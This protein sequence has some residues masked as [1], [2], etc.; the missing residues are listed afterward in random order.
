VERVDVSTL[1][2]HRWSLRARHFV[3]ATGAI[4]NARLLLASNDV[5]TVGL[6]NE[7]DNVG[8]YFMDHLIAPGG[9]TLVARSG[10]VTGL[11]L[12]QFD[13]LQHRPKALLVLSEK[14]RARHRL[15]G[16]TA[17]LF[18]KGAGIGMQSYGYLTSAIEADSDIDDL[19][20]HVGNILGDV[21]EVASHLYY[22]YLSGDPQPQHYTIYSQCEQ[23]PNRD[24]RVI[25]DKQLD[26]LGM[27]RAALDWRLSEQD[28]LTMYKGL[29]LIGEEIGRSGLGRVQLRYQDLEQPLPTGVTGDYHHMGTTRM[30]ENPRYGV[31]DKNCRLHGIANLHVA[32]SSVFT[33]SGS[34]NPT[35]PLLALALRLA[36]RLR[37]ELRA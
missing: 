4:E 7:Y 33:T 20:R 35:L 3:L 10:A 29:R 26:A 5:E 13:G 11:F 17:M 28:R 12:D 25:L 9:G 2:G 18:P 27:P 34:A 22:E 8:R 1:D 30:H 37:S 31:V 6:G 15:A 19:W 36:D 14:A 21:G 16:H 32:G 23:V 24:S